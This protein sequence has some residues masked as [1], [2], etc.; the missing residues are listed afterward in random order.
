MVTMTWNHH[1]IQPANPIQQLF[2]SYTACHFA[3][4]TDRLYQWRA[5]DLYDGPQFP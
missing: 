2:S 4:K 1:A 5:L 3:R